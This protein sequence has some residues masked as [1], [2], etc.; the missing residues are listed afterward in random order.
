VALSCNHCCSGKATSIS[1]SEC[2]SCSLIY[3]ACIALAPYC[4]LWPVRL[5]HIFPLFLINGT[6]FGKNK[7]LLNI[8]CVLILTANLCEIFPIRR[9][10]QRYIIINVHLSACKVTVILVRFSENFNSLRRFSKNNQV[11]IFTKIRRP[12][13]AE[14]FTRTDGQRDRHDEGNSCFSQFCESA[15]S[16]CSKR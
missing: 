8:K 15:K 11:S 12:V 2:V 16:N 3:P 1:Y 14:L 9:I 6:I 13:G 5:Y 10:I 7:K 4:H